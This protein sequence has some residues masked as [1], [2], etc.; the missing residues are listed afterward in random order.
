MRK[1]VRIVGVGKRRVGTSAAGNSYDF[2]PIS[3]LFK[4]DQMAGMKAE[5]TNVSA[6]VLP[7]ELLGIDQEYDMV[8][9]YSNFKLYIDAVI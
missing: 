8:M 9:H 7:H 4:D 6:D 2:T 3:V 5:T 1:N